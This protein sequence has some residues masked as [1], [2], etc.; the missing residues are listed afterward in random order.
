MTLTAGKLI[1]AK[2]YNTID[3]NFDDV[4]LLL[5]GEGANGSTTII[6]SS[7]NNNVITA[8]GDA[9]ISTA[10]ADPFGNSDAGVLAFDG[11]GDY[12][13]AAESNS[14]LTFGT[15]DFTVEFFI[16]Y[17]TTNTDD[18][19]LDWRNSVGGQDRIVLFQTGGNLTLFNPNNT[20]TTIFTPSTNIWYHVSLCRSS[21]TL[22]AYVDGIQ[23]FNVANA[24]NYL[25]PGSTNGIYIGAIAFGSGFDFDGYISNI[26]ITKGVARYTA[27]FTPP[28]QPFFP[29]GAN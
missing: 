21:G 20:N 24:V 3:P 15:G 12:L 5:S 6:D 2:D 23:V 25:P 13:Q 9:S 10:I 16:Y 14:N 22:R 7:N 29:G 1:L 11:A 28:T 18:L 19:I 27:N 17:N 4:S 8:V 26:R